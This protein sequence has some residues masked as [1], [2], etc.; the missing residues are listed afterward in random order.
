M[1]LYSIYALVILP[2]EPF[3]YNYEVKMKALWVGAWIHGD[4]E[5]DRH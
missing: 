4:F 3:R 2:I 1:N 5:I